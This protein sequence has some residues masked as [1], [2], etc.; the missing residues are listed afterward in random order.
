M[1]SVG[2]AALV[3][4]TVLYALA[5]VGCNGFH[6]FVLMLHESAFSQSSI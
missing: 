5:G 3:C 1:A 2:A 6:Q 4:V